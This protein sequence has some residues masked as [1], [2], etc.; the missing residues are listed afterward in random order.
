MIQNKYPAITWVPCA[1]H[2]LNLLLKDIGKMPSVKQTLLDANHIVKFIREHQ[3]SYAL[4]RSKPPTKA[5]HVFCATRFATAYYVLE[6]LLKVKRALI[7]T[8]AD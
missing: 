4:F 3:L 6:G 5:L 2:T 8:V 1:A 7:E